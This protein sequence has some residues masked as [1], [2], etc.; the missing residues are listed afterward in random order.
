MA[1]LIALLAAGA[2][3]G[4]AAVYFLQR[5]KQSLDSAW[6]DSKVA[7]KDSTAA[8]TRAAA[9]QVG[10]SADQ[11]SAAADSAKKAASDLADQVNKG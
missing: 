1:K 5:N 9:D 7:A 11:V 8:W 10:K 3:I 6:N 4:A 2:A